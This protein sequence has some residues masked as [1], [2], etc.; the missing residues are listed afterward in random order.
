MDDLGEATR[1]TVY[2]FCRQ[3]V[4]LAVNVGVG[5]DLVAGPALVESGCPTSDK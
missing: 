1:A 3:T 2:F 4:C 5:V